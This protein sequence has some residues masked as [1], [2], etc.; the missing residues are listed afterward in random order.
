MFAS[1]EVPACGPEDV[2]EDNDLCPQ[3][4]ALGEGFF[5]DLVVSSSDPDFYRCGVLQ[6]ETIDVDAIFSHAQGDVDIRLWDACGGNL[7][8]VG[9]SVTD[10]E[11]VSWS[12][13]NGPDIEVVLE[14]L[15]YTP[16]GGTPG[17]N[18]YDLLIDIADT[19]PGSNFCT[20]L[21]N[22][23]GFPTL[24]SA[25]GSASIAANDLILIAEDLPPSQNGLFY[26]GPNQIQAPFGNGI[27]C[28][29]GGVHRLPVLNSGALGRLSFAVDYTALPASGAIL[30]GSFWNFQAWYRD[31]IAGGATFNLSDGYAILFLP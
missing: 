25:Q 23:T 19:E 6:G 22:S 31:P 8:A 7:L 29:G 30:P 28:V 12:N 27:R 10:D 16:G 17:C 1:L 2:F 3:A 5:P 13:L 11:Q 4:A 24:I 18:T 26:Y 21:P 20:S 9:T 15:Y 14:V